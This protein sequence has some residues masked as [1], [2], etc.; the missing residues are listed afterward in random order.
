[1]EP[2][3]KFRL[4]QTVYRLLD[5]EAHKATVSGVQDFDAPTISYLIDFESGV[6]GQAKEWVRPDVIISELAHQ[7][8]VEEL[9]AKEKAAE[10]AA[11]LAQAEFDKDKA[12][13]QAQ[14]ESKESE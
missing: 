13:E 12:G 10:E 6:H 11:A 1:M 2:I 14:E 5:G 8:M 9:A 3:M 7:V 4:G